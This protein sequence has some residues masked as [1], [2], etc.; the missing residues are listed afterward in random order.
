MMPAEVQGQDETR[1]EVIDPCHI[2]RWWPL[3]RAGLVT[4]VE[5]T[6]PDWIP[7]DVYR[8]LRNQ[9]AALWLGYF[10]TMYVGF[11]VVNEQQNPF[12]GDRTLMVWCTYMRVSGYLDSFLRKVLSDAQESG[13]DV[14]T[15]QSPR[16]GWLRRLFSF[17]FK[18]R[19][20]IYECRL[21]VHHG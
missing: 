18:P 6:K 9:T 13:F 14:V 10:G 5:K 4:I 19:D 3:V 8:A 7:E 15:F 21:G 11:A 12:N 20:T 1:I 2:Q 16:R 17:G